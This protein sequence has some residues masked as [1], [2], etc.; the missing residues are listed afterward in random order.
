MFT[1]AICLGLFALLC[2][3][4]GVIRDTILVNKT[5]NIFLSVVWTYLGGVAS[6]T[7]MVAVI[8][9]Y[10]L[11]P[12]GAMQCIHNTNTTLALPPRQQEFDLAARARLTKSRRMPTYTT[13]ITHPPLLE[14]PRNTIPACLV[15][16]YAMN[17]R[18]SKK[19][20]WHISIIVRTVMTPLTMTMT[21]LECNR[22]TTRHHHVKAWSAMI[23]R[24]IKYKY[25]ALN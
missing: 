16:A 22:Y 18:S 9:K 12:K 25:L 14:T 6:L 3:V 2:I 11:L 24:F 15:V 20:T 21:I 10:V 19:F 5:G 13:P 17:S 7:V 4:Y 23:Y 1:I 8:L